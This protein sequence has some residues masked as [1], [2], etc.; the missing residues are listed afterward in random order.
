[1]SP[2]CS[3]SK[4]LRR[5]QKSSVRLKNGRRK[6]KLLKP[7]GEVEQQLFHGEYALVDGEENFMSPP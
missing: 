2:E 1:M 7:C 3:W 5:H 4:R 6:G